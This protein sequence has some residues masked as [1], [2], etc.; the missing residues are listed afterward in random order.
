[1][2]ML[3]KK[4]FVVLTCLTLVVS[5]V[6]LPTQ[7]AQ[8]SFLSDF[9]GEL[10]VTALGCSGILDKVT[11]ALSSLTDSLMGTEVPV[12]DATTHSKE[13]CLDAIAYTAAKIVLAKITQSTLNWIN[14]GFQGSPTFVQNPG[15][16]FA[17][18]ANE[19][20]STFTAQIAFDP[21][22]F[23]FGRITA[24]NI[25]KSIQNQLD[26]NASVTSGNLLNY[27]N[28]SILPYRQRFDNFTADFL[29]GG[30]WDGY[31]AVTQITNA[32]P[33]DAYIQSV[34]H[35]GPVVTSAN[36][37]RN[38]INEVTQELQQSGGF[39]ALKK[40]VEPEDYSPASDDPTFDRQSATIAA[41]DSDPSL[42][43]AGKQWLFEHTCTRYET[44][45]PGTAIAQQ[46]NISLGTSQRQLELADE[47]NE[48]ISAVFDALI[49][50]LFN[51]GVQSLS[52][53]D[54]AGSNVNVLGGYGTNTNGSTLGTGS[55]SSQNSGSQWYNQNQN[56]DLKE[57]IAPG[58]V[59]DD[60]DC[61]FAFTT[62]PAG[63]INA[64]AGV[65]TGNIKDIN[66]LRKPACNQGIAVLQRAY[67]EAL[68][69]EA[70][71]LTEA[72][73]WINYADYCVPGP[74]PDW[75]SYATTAVSGLQERFSEIANQ[76][77]E[78]DRASDSYLELKYF[79]G[80][81]ADHGDVANLRNSSNAYNAIWQTLREKIGGWGYKEYID[82]RY[83]AAN[84]AM[85]PVT[86][87]IIQEYSKKARYQSLVDQ[88]GA[89]AA[90]SE[91]MFLRLQN[92]RNN[93][94]QGEA[95]LTPGTEEYKDY[96]DNQLKIFSRLVSQLKD[97][98][99][100]ESVL[101]D[102]TLANDEI[103]YLAKPV[104]GLI[105]E[106]VSETSGLTSTSPRTRRAYGE[107]KATVAD[108]QNYGWTGDPLSSYTN[109][110]SFLPDISISASRS[111][112]GYIYIGHYV[113]SCGANTVGPVS[114][115]EIRLGGAAGYGFCFDGDTDLTY[116]TGDR[117]E[118]HINAY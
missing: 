3:L 111:G 2:K 116:T 82:D 72:I 26:Y 68:K 99:D 52:G 112:A 70:I 7:K 100:V 103:K 81:A 30:G 56:F 22:R 113:N 39:L 110:Q 16:F 61:H 25:V 54:P 74:R 106:C 49:K 8:A 13:S 88:S 92:I 93:V 53:E 105:A 44:K 17:S 51:K 14:S 32:N 12:T 84:P 35:I 60:P 66:I 91:A 1:M 6:A 41:Q 28:D 19:Q 64:P 57:A 36:E 97:V 20:V 45:T 62:D 23:P 101:A 96:M 38:P 104:S 29:Y 69:A 77:D 43:E 73:R 95:T 83:S 114:P 117:F 102:L 89:L 79:T 4:C 107:A 27:D 34:N 18:I 63:T 86:S 15:S 40:C 85:P 55:G 65:V 37:I 94:L 21:N 5:P 31:L 11:S 59:I 115:F 46:M 47:L 48:S 42:A 58:G 9:G 50:Q 67:A 80:F 109:Q 78:D 24:Q 75:Y 118:S 76:N 98:D 108:F 90:E 33:F 71:K 87:L 10:A